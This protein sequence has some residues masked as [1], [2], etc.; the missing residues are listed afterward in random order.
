MARIDGLADMPRLLALLASRSASLLNYSDL[1]R[2]LGMPT[3]TLKRY[4]ALLEATFLVHLLPA[5]STNLGLRLVKAPK[6]LL[7]DTGLLI[8]QI[9][10]D[11]DRL[12][13]DALIGGHVLE[14]FVAMELQKQR[15]WSTTCPGIF[16]FRTTTGAEVD[17]VL[18]SRR[19]EVVGIEVKASA[20]VKSDDFRGLRGLAAMAGERF[21]RG[22][23]LYT[24]PE[25]LPFGK[26]LLAVPVS[27]LWEPP[28]ESAS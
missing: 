19:G 17:I 28:S 8:D 26:N 21:L 22:I 24:G 1:S 14:N 10:L 3:S 11:E 15:G 16:H 9:G 7:N 13:A 20:T 18:E 2:S 12:K 5:W 4:M 27:A 25:M 23:V 6:L